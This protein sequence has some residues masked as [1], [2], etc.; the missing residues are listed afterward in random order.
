[1]LTRFPRASTRSALVFLAALAAV[2][3]FVAIIRAVVGSSG[4][5]QGPLVAEIRGHVG[6]GQ[7]VDAGFS[8]SISG[9]FVVKNTSDRTLELDRVELVGLQSGIFRGAYV[10]PYPHR[11]AHPHQPYI[12]AA[13]GYQVPPDGRVLPRVTVAP[14]TQVAIVMGF[15]AKQGRHA[16]A[17]IG[18]LYHQ[19][20]NTYRRDV[21]FSGAVCA[22]VAKYR[23]TC[24]PPQFG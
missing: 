1:M 10:V 12:G 24:N 3:L 2:A 17:R 20:S 21:A 23:T 9:P 4:D 5:D 13:P 7:P 16:W 11:P 6:V 19:G 8:V 18:L 14:D 22:P 15:R